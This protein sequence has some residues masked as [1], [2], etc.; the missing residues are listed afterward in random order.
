MKI[1]IYLAAGNGDLI[2]TTGVLLRLKESY[3]DIIIDFLCLRNQAYLLQDNPSINQLLF[4][5]DYNISKH[6]TSR[7]YDKEIK[8]TF[9]GYDKYINIWCP[10]T[11][12]FP[13]EKLQL[14][15]NNGFKLPYTRDQINGAVFYRQSDIDIVKQFYAD[16]IKN[17]NKI[18]LIED[19]SVGGK[20]FHTSWQLKQIENNHKIGEILQQRDFNVISNNINN[21]ISCKSLNLIQIKLFFELYGYVFFGLSSGMT[22]IFFSDSEYYTDKHFFIAGAPVWNYCKYIKKM[23]NYYYYHNYDWRFLDANFRF[24]DR[25]T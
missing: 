13:A 14:L 23:P 11:G 16:N 4:F 12:D 17:S 24:F 25:P 19:D 2:N 7:T 20:V 5:E 22:T 9:N 10:T 18:I 6:V 3:P 15:I 8:A 1:L 21:T